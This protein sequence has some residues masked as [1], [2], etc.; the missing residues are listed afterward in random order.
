MNGTSRGITQ[1]TL[2]AVAML[3]LGL[4]AVLFGLAGPSSAD[5]EIGDLPPT[6]ESDALDCVP[7]VGSKAKLS[8]WAASGSY[9]EWQH[10]DSTP[11]ADPD[12][13]DGETN[14]ENLQMLGTAESQNHVTQAGQGAVAGFWTNFQPNN[15]QDPFVGPP[16]YPSDPRGSWSEPKTEGGPEQDASGVYPVGNPDVGGNWFY[17]SQGT[18]EVPEQSH[19]D[20]RWPI[21]ERTLTPAVAPTECVA[22]VE[23][24]VPVNGDGDGDGDG[25]GDGDGDVAGEAEVL[26]IEAEAPA[27]APT[28]VDAGLTAQESS[29]STLWLLAGA[30]LALMGAAL[31][32]TPARA[33][34]KRAR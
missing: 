21:L 8:D 19:T 18:A 4:G 16:S 31:G 13:Q 28:A 7:S 5:V 6:V 14:P 11:P 17:R 24:S 34:G 2:A 9:T 23:S 33:R 25:T 32:L 3:A 1:R 29:N 30:A 20:Y 15:T 22:G 26:G 27:A 12:G 10:D